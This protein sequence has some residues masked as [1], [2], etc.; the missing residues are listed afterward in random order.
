M[1][2]S[3]L[4]EYLKIFLLLLCW[5]LSNILRFCVYDNLF[6][7]S[8]DKIQITAQAVLHNQNQTRIQKSLRLL[9]GTYNQI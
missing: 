8:S 2:I 4:L 1:E 9:A 7:I 6:N 3:L 5:Y